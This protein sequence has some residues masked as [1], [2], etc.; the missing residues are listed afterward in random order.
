VLAVISCGFSWGEF[1]DEA[2]EPGDVLGERGALQGSQRYLALLV[3]DE[4]DELLPPDFRVSRIVRV[5][6][7]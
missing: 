1:L 2:I 7:P 6:G 4:R 5:S 3:S